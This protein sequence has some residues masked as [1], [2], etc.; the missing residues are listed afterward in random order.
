MVWCTRRTIGSINTKVEA[1]ESGD[2]DD[3]LDRGC[4]WFN[5][6]MVLKLAALGEVTD[7]HEFQ[8]IYT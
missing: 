5:Y 3:A 4:R 6:N 8:R 7:E 1:L 2:D